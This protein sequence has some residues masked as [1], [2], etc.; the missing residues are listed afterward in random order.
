MNGLGASYLQHG[1]FDEA[2]N[3]CGQPRSHYQP[4]MQA[5]ARLNPAEFQKIQQ[6]ADLSL[7]NQ[8]VTFTVY[9]DARGTEKIFPF[10]LIP[11]ILTAKEW[12]HIEDGIVQRLTALN[13]FLNDVYHDQKIL[14]DNIVPTDLIVN[15]SNYCREMSGINVPGNVHVHVGGIDLIRGDDG[16]YMVLED[17]LRSPS[18]VSY[19]IENRTVMGRVMP[20]LLRQNKVRPVD[21]YPQMLFDSL[22]SL[23]KVEQP[24]VAVLTPGAYNSAYFEHTFLA[25]SMGAELVEGQDLLVEND[26]L[27]MKNTEGLKRIDVLFR[28]IDDDFID[29]LVFRGDSMLG[30][31]GLMHAYRSGNVV[32]A[33]APGN[34][35]A[36]DKAIYAYVP[37]IIKYYLGEEPIL[38]NVPTYLC[39]RPNDLAYVL[40]HLA[41]LVIKPTDA[42]GGYGLLIGP[43]ATQAELTEFH[44]K[45]K[46]NP[47]GY[48]AQPVQNLSTHP[49]FVEEKGVCG[50]YPRHVDLRPYAVCG[51][52]GKV[53][54]LPGGLTRVALRKGSL[55][56]N[57]SQGGGSKDTWVLR[58]DDDRPAEGAAH[59]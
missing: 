14:K 53:S 16:E 45:L 13:L 26:C 38:A 33:S 11:R 39:A 30:V 37:E 55:V 17:N 43:A 4:F 1:F 35:V 44:S 36:D 51:A 12:Q 7:L 48:I 56:I 52:N 6:M 47:S 57:S 42:S 3:A 34:G 28:R 31:A 24:T 22:T 58:A 29:P 54:V 25:S 41:Q 20:D 59:A 32:I 27:Y 10:D 18:G 15:S 49:T 46:A 40:D 8:G 23:S 2:F 21:S 9:S 50:L 19:V 5:M